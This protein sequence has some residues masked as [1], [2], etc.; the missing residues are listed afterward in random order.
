MLL[1][2]VA[3]TVIIIWLGAFMI[4]MSIMRSPA[5]LA[6]GI[7]LGLMFLPQLK[8]DSPFVILDKGVLL[9]LAAGIG[10][11]MVDPV[12]LPRFQ[13]SV[14]DVPIIALCTSGLAAG[15]A[16]DLG[17]YNAAATAAQLIVHWGIPFFT[18][19]IV[20]T[21]EK[22]A[23]VLLKTIILGALLYVP[24]CLFEMKMSPVLHSMVYGYAPR[25][26][27]DHLHA[28]RFGLWR[29]TVFMEMGL[30]LSLFMG[31]CSTIT[32][33]CA[34]SGRVTK[35][36]NLSTHLIAGILGI[37]TFFCVSSGAI[38]ITIAGWC[39]IL[40]SQLKL[41]RWILFALFLFAMGYP[42]YRMTNTGAIQIEI[43]EE[44]SP[45]IAA[46]KDSLKTRID[47]EDLFINKW[48]DSPLFGWTRWF[49][50]YTDGGYA[51]P[52][53]LWIIILA[54]YGLVGWVSWSLMLGTPALLAIRNADQAF[55]FRSAAFP[56]AL[57]VLMFW[58]D[59]LMNA[60]PNV[61]YGV[62]A[63]TASTHWTIRTSVLPTGIDAVPRMRHPQRALWPPRQQRVER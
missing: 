29:P 49:F 23:F 56:M 43:S 1:S 61:L 31:I 36:A 22:N 62:L 19:R 55:G 30:Q 17:S 45:D 7:M 46:R 11:L 12:H 40:S 28:L 53:A 10:V 16:N 44:D 60:F 2:P 52:D 39:V 9:A 18:G 3:V 26:G 51:I 48:K 35:V 32:L 54:C 37:V 15:L 8:V 58:L 59:S 57:C 50:M 47:S 34:V 25:V 42:V 41:H 33:W 14:Y 6:G 38:L 21:S 63:G 4:T 24:F 5:A 13:W 27:N 20:F